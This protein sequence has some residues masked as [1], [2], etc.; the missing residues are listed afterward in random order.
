MPA[1]VPSLDG[2]LCG[3]ISSSTRPLG[4]GNIQ[5]TMSG[6]ASEPITIKDSASPCEPMMPKRI[7]PAAGD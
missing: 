2:F 7:A 1:S 3:E 4:S 5:S 6:A